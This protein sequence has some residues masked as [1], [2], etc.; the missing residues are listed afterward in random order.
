M[1][2]TF[3]RRGPLL[4]SCAVAVSAALTGFLAS[5]ASAST[6]FLGKFPNQ[7]VVSS[8]VP[9]THTP[10]QPGDGD[11]NPYGVAVVHQSTGQLVAGDV[12]VSNFNDSSNLQGTGRT[13]V[14]ISPSGQLSTFAVLPELPG[15]TGLT[16]ALAILP[17]GFV[18]VGSLPTNQG[19]LEGSASAGALVF[20]NSAGQ[21][22]KTVSGGDINGPWDLTAISYGDFSEVFV[23]N[24]L[25]G[26]QAGGGMTVFGGTV[27][28]LLLDTDSNGPHVLNNSVIATGFGER[29][30]PNALVVGPTGVGVGRDGTLFVADTVGSAIR[31]IP[32]ATRR[33]SNAGTGYLV[34]SG[35]FLN[36]PLGLAVAPRGD[37]LTVN[38]GDGQIVD[39]TP[40][41]MQVDHRFLDNTPP[42]PPTTT[43]VGQ[44]A[45]FGL[46]IAP[47]HGGVYFVDDNANQLDQ[48]TP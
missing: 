14:E 23:T 12:L 8:T 4:A 37:I 45:L 44:G 15:G 6:T 46:A 36:G 39:T 10:P 17:H 22:V 29:T 48:L 24:V 30:D 5:P 25:N 9:P 43:A 47:H 27:V 32:D 2:R 35:G 38:G 18:V 21:V 41:G 31:A 19:S 1:K 3:R 40:N 28:R 34:S 42:S 16:T 11:V 7:R 13:I 20:L 33:F 26:T